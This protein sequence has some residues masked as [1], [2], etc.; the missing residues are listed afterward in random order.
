[1]YTKSYVLCKGEFPSSSKGFVI[2]SI[3]YS[4]IFLVCRKYI[5]ERISNELSDEVRC[6][7]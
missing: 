3:L 2:S 6:L 5:S 7:V 4:I 1:M